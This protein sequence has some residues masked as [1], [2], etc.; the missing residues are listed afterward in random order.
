MVSLKFCDS[1]LIFN[2]LILILDK[3]PVILSDVDGVSCPETK[4]KEQNTNSHT[5]KRFFHIV[6]LII[7]DS[8]AP[9]NYSLYM[10]QAQ[11]ILETIGVD[12]MQRLCDHFG[13]E[14]VYIP[15]RVPY[16]DRSERIKEEFVSHVHGG[17][18]CM[19][20]YA[21]VGEHFN[22]STRRVQSIIAT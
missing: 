16:V 11:E 4:G 14:S 7:L 5:N 13:G 1:A 12:A 20:A 19:N 6:P 22:L 2:A 8:I 9:P 10:T 21:L 3:L 15:K 17:A 18:T